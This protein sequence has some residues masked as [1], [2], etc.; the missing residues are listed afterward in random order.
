[1][2]KTGS[3]YERLWKLPLRIENLSVVPKP[4]LQITTSSYQLPLCCF[5]SSIN[6]N[7]FVVMVTRYNPVDDENRVP[8]STV[9]TYKLNYKDTVLAPLQSDYSSDE[10]SDL[11]PE[12][13]DDEIENFD[14]VGNKVLDVK[15]IFSQFTYSPIPHPKFT[16]CGE[17]FPSVFNSTYNQLILLGLNNK[18]TAFGAMALPGSGN[19]CGKILAC[20]NYND[21]F[22][23]L[24]NYKMNNNLKECDLTVYKF[25][26]NFSLRS[27]SKIKV[28]KLLNN[29]DNTLWLKDWY[30]SPN[31]KKLLMVLNNG[32]LYMIDLVSK[33]CVLKSTVS[34]MFN[35]F[36]Q[37]DI[38]SFS[39]MFHSVY[40]ERMLITGSN[41]QLQLYDWWKKESLGCISLPNNSKLTHVSISTNHN[42][43]SVCC[44][45]GDVLIYALTATK[46]KLLYNLTC[47]ELFDGAHIYAYSAYF[48]PSSQEVCVSYLNSNV[49]I[50][51]LARNISSLKE[52][53]RLKV[54]CLFTKHE[55]CKVNLPKVLLK[56]LLFEPMRK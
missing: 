46:L 54:R 15:R 19:L 31:M 9:L 7:H 40:E 38:N 13:T 6:P 12:Y 49:V 56:Y 23:M 14:F 3:R 36:D 39:A 2:E 22:I 55:I 48:T 18:S 26:N 50:W 53:C 24:I 51:Q 34:A 16:T 33:T 37:D 4:I 30:I 25:K 1:M 52:M 44:R 27:Q 21:L 8:S 42:R 47:K 28:E 11:T 43:V 35:S 29:I 20:I 32:D 45:R 10:Y 5:I 17:F 41:S